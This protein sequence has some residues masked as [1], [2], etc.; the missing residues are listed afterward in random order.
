MPALRRIPPALRGGKTCLSREARRE[1]QQLTGARPRAF[2][3]QAF[4][5]WLIIF[6]TAGLAVRIDRVWMTML[7][8]CVVATRLNVLG[9]LMHEQVHMLGLRGRFG[10]SLA[11]MLVAYPLG[12][13]VEGYA[14]VHLSHHQHYFSDR[15]PD[16][17]RKS[18]PDWTF[19]MPRGR[20]LRLFLSDVLGLS[21]LKLLRGKRLENLHVFR[22]PHPAPKWL[23]PLYYATIAGLLTYTESWGTFALYG[24]VPLMTLLPLIVRLFAICEHVYGER[25]AGTIETSPMIV[26]RWWEKL[27]LPNLNFSLHTY[28]HFFPGVAWC[29]LPRVHALFEREKLVDEAAV[30]YGYAAYLKY[31]QRPIHAREAAS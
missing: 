2:L 10:D 14:R 9:L 23:R 21:F 16:F 28:H 8:I 18:G 13:T 26:L 30:F 31:L 17:T 24:I 12:V 19:P 15:D 20:L 3:A 27:L 29:N 25:G 6:G 1:I 11:N 7:A 22:R 5:T 4:R